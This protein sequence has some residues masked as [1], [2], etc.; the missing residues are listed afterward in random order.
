MIFRRRGMLL[1]TVAAV[2]GC[3]MLKGG[4][5]AKDD[6]KDKPAGSG[7]ATGAGASEQ[8]PDKMAFFLGRKWGFA[9]TFA[10]LGEA[11]SVSKNMGQA[12]TLA[13][14]LG[15]TAPTEPP[16]DGAID[17]MRS[18]TLAD[19]IKKKHGDKAAAAYGAGLAVTD[20]YFGAN[21]D[22]PITS[23]LAD[24]EKHARAAGIPESVWK[25]KL[26]AVKAAP[27]DEDGVKAL[28]SALE[29]HYQG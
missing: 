2:V 8:S 19:E 21:L 26:D 1:V 13:K 23:Q 17:A 22:S 24:L 10:M 12:T 25:A 11:D 20:A 3:D 29:A 6:S 16:K 27:S 15:I 28:A 5:S 4:E 7:K 18:P 14:G 9:C